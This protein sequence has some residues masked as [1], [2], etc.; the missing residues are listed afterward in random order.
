MSGG[1]LERSAAI[2]NNGHDY[3]NIFGKSIMNSLNNGKS[4]EYVTVY[5]VG[6][7]SKQSLEDA[8]KANYTVNIKIYGDAIRE[9]STEGIGQLS[10]NS[11]YSYF[12][13]SIYPFFI[14]G[15]SYF[16]NNAAGLLCFGRRDG[17]NLYADGF[18]SVLV[19]Q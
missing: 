17:G 18:R 12:T 2:V 1:I 15:G 19:A 5:P 10:W 8:N 9:T 7:K 13:G 4:T 16:A 6:E 11:N 14:R 3:L